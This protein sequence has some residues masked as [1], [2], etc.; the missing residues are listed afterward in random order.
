MGRL[1]L[2]H[3]AVA[4]RGHGVF[5]GARAEAGRTVSGWRE[6]CE[7]RLFFAGQAV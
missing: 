6:E 2:V 5:K 1:A 3:L 4:S 7:T